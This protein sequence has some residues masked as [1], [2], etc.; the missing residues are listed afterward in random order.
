MTQK[1][2]R[3]PGTEPPGCSRWLIWGLLAALVYLAFR[4]FWAPGPEGVPVPYSQFRQEVMAGNV[5]EVTVRGQ[6]ILGTLREPVKRAEEADTIRITEF[7][8]TLPAFGDE[9]LLPLLLEHGAE[10]EVIPEGDTAWLQVFLIG[11]LPFLLLG[12]ILYMSMRRSAG[13]AQSFFSMGQ[14]GARKYEREESA[15]T[16]DDVA[17]AAGAKKELQE[18]VEFLGSSL[19]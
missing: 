13:A 5:L 18:V 14:S 6:Q 3:R 11:F 9:A 15:T 19:T 2:T 17:G 4:P 10:V 1:H 12:G 16:F 7:A 8:T